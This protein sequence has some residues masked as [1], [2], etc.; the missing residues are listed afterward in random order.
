MSWVEWG[1]VGR[2]VK[3]HGTDPVRVGLAGNVAGRVGSG[4]EVCEISRHGSV[5][6]GS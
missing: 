1:R 4:W 5:R 2:C 6:V 3:Y